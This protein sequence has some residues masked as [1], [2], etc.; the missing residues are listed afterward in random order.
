MENYRK[1]RQNAYKKTKR[2]A[3]TPIDAK[4]SKRDAYYDV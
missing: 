4:Q 3:K 1:E 2:E